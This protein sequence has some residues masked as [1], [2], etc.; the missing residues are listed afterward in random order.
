MT[1]DVP[2]PECDLSNLEVSVCL[3]VSVVNSGEQVN[4]V[5]KGEHAVLLKLFDSVPS[6]TE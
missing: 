2:F 3:C 6:R 5:D 4:K 1:E